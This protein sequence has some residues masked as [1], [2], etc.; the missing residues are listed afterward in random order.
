MTHILG[1]I[2]S[3]EYK[4]DELEKVTAEKALSGPG[5]KNE[6]RPAKQTLAESINDV[7]ETVTISLAVVFIL[8]CFIFRICVVDGNSM[9]E[10]LID[11]EKLLV[12][13]LFGSPERGDIVVFH[14]TDYFKEP[15][16]KRVIATENE[17]ID[18]EKLSDGT[19]AVTIYDENMENPVLLDES[20]ATYKEGPGYSSYSRYPRQV[21][22]GCIF[23]M[24][25]NRN[26]SSDSRSD[27]VGMVDERR[28]LGKVLLR[29]LPLSK[30]GTVSD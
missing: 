4:Q 29:L 10:T 28:V 13:D 18:I 5:N 9:N 7:F 1:D 15:L 24:G 11:N 23:V 6:D 20:Y 27:A 2:M 22:E 8:F 16:V 21:P 3:E 30:F 12:S 19:L 14:E 25:D 26:N 17:W